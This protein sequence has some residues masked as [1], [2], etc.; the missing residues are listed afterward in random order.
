[1]PDTFS[2]CPDRVRLKL[3]Q[4]KEI[5]PPAGMAHEVLRVLGDDQVG[6]EKV[7]A[8]VEKSPELTLRILRCAN[9]AYYGQQREI[10]SIREAVI[11]VLGLTVTN[12]LIVAL[13]LGKPFDLRRC[14]CFPAQR[15]WFMAVMAAHISRE[16][17]QAVRSRQV[18]PATAFTGG[19]V[20][21]LGVLALVH[22]FPQQMEGAFAEQSLTLEQQR[23]EAELG[24]G[25]SVVGGWLAKHW[26]LPEEL[27]Q[28]IIHQGEADYQGENLA[29][30]GCV[31]A[32]V[33][34]AGDFY[35]GKRFPAGPVVLAQGLLEPE[36]IEA[37]VKKS[38]EKV[39]EL[40]ALA[41]VLCGG[42]T[43]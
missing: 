28:V 17:A 13:S 42:G 14:A 20:H 39:D 8:L 33:Q 9:S 35:E 43:T 23:M 30:V 32:A 40:K 38:F 6:L 19:L 4:L 34:L 3:F 21:G 31:T 24:V 15:H 2:T 29:L 10:T 12:G 11:R 25:P 5:P 27:V 37:V 26:G 36:K 16:F 1:M 18:D 22:T 41:L 7:A